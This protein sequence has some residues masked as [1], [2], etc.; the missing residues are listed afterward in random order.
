VAELTPIE[1]LQPSLLDRLTD[2][3]PDKQLE[4]RD[5]RVVSNRQLRA[6]VLR[7]LEWL[8]NV[9]RQPD[10]ELL[11]EFPE[12]AKSVLFYG[13]PDFTGVTSSSVSS[14]QIESV[15]IEAIERFEPR[16][17]PGTVRVRAVVDEASMDHHAVCFEIA[18]DLWASPAPDHLYLRTEL[19]LETGRCLVTENPH[20]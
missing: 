4:S 7:D 17:M 15:V 5:R 9:A 8:L 3:E 1:R 10:Q 11:D 19:D 18:G 6:A 13:V 14:E 2:D 20:G 16:L 12:A